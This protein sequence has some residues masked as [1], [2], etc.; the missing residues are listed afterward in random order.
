MCYHQINVVSKHIC[1]PLIL[2]SSSNHPMTSLHMQIMVFATFQIE[3]ANRRVLLSQSIA[4][5]MAF[6]LRADCASVLLP[7]TPQP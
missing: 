1:I 4:P 3:Q 5:H 2:A 6:R 7:E